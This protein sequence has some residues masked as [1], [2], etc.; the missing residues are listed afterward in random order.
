[1]TDTVPRP[2]IEGIKKLRFAG[3]SRTLIPELVAYIEHIEAENKRLHLRV[4]IATDPEWDE[5]GGNAAYF[6]EA[7]PLPL[8]KDCG[9]SMAQARAGEMIFLCANIK[10]NPMTSH[11]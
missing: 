4:K 6:G 7:V 11:D 5:V 10:C 1:M 3:G 9:E 2:D 8:C